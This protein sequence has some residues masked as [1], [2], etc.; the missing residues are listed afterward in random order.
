MTPGLLFAG[1]LAGG[2]LQISSTAAIGGGCARRMCRFSAKR[3]IVRHFQARMGRTGC[4]RR[5]IGAQNG[6]Q[7]AACGAAA[8]RKRGM[9]PS[10]G[11]GEGRRRRPWPGA[12]SNV[13]RARADTTPSGS[14]DDPER[15]VCARRAA[16]GVPPL[17]AQEK[18]MG[19][20]T[21]GRR[22]LHEKK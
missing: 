17:G 10:G 22:G 18:T 15:Y 3:A 1:E 7:I 9:K 13:R 8:A 5:E 2:F 19:V 4:A 20:S 6:E 21:R 14:V 12:M 16:G 11:K